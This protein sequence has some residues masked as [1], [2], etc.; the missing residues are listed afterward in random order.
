[1]SCF[2]KT[3]DR[4]KNKEINRTLRDDA[5]YNSTKLLL[6]GTGDSGKT[7]FTKQTKLLYCGG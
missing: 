1:M 5:Q 2:G 6:L 3:A 4:E 7:T